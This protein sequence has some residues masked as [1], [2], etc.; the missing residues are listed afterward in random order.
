MPVWNGVYLMS[1]WNRRWHSNGRAHARN[2]RTEER[3]KWINTLSQWEIRI[4]I[5]VFFSS[6]CCFRDIKPMINIHDFTTKHGQNKQWK[7]RKKTN[8]FNK[9]WISRINY[10]P[11]W[12]A[13][14]GQ[15]TFL[16]W[17][18]RCYIDM[19]RWCDDAYTKHP[20]PALFTVENNTHLSLVCVR[21]PCASYGS[22]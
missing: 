2:G 12:D 19:M 21:G 11:F 4:Y 15:S 20:N 8:R 9:I 16:I 7:C 3:A 5:F 14:I 1:T 10:I 13:F 18:Q 22:T 17:C 6:H